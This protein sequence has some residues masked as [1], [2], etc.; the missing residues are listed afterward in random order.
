MGWGNWDV[1]VYVAS[2]LMTL[3]RRFSAA[4]ATI[5]H[6]LRGLLVDPVATVRLQIA[7]SLN[8]L[9][10]VDRSIMWEMAQI[11][12]ATE[13]SLGVLAF[14]V[15]GPMYR[16]A[17]VEPG[18][19]EVLVSELLARLP[20]E[21]AD[22][23]ASKDG[24]F[25]EAIGY[26]AAQQWVGSGSNRAGGWIDAWSSDIV[27]GERYLWHVISALRRALFERFQ[28]AATADDAAVQDRARG[29][30]EAIVS[31]CRPVLDRARQLMEA[32]SPED[33]LEVAARL[34][35]A[36]DKLVDHICNQ[37]YFGSGAY[38]GQRDE[39]DGPGLGSADAMRRFLGEYGPILDAIGELGS[40]HTTHHLVELYEHLVV[41]APEVIFDRIAA[42]LVGPGARGGYHFESM[43]SDVL[44]R[45]VRRYLA[46]HR[47]VFDNAD[48]R[49]SLLK[50]LN[51]FSEAG[52]PDA[53]QLL[54][55]LPDLLR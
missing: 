1:R 27:A 22:E 9:W 46:D 23:D 12:A 36:G 6:R 39:N 49:E 43:G 4:D 11:V 41:A 21:A 2:S 32:G 37:F 18:Q 33:D 15:S 47:T 26:F 24:S 13:D 45:L 16:L 51:L 25:D 50:L 29:V 30:V 40:A 7:Q 35:R 31:A 28:A 34:Y 44:V 5:V 55:E 48:R 14:F 19:C 3:V 17:G 8:T 52:W 10:D 54:Y 20:R 38:D 42:L 53:L